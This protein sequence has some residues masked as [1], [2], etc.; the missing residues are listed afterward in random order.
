MIIV[1]FDNSLILWR[2]QNPAEHLR[3]SFFTGIVKNFQPL[4][5]FAKQTHRKCLTE[6]SISLCN[7]SSDIY[8]GYLA[9]QQNYKKQRNIY[10][11]SSFF[12][13][14]F[15]KDKFMSNE[16]H[17]QAFWFVPNVTN[18]QKRVSQFSQ[19]WS[20]HVTQKFKFFYTASFAPADVIS[21]ERPKLS[22]K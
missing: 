12:L 19:S 18:A 3:W 4:T 21:D 1:S 5:I 8:I 13:K 20:R 6:L 17:T 9:V 22:T 10:K 14:L 11:N 2:I 15:Q 16:S 7:H